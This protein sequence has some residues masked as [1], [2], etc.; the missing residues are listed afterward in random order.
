MAGGVIGLSV[1]CAVARC[2][3]AAQNDSAAR[4]LAKLRTDLTL[5]SVYRTLSSFGSSA[6]CS[7]CAVSV[8][9]AASSRRPIER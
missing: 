5:I 6:A 3:N 2:D 8:S 1:T 4:S 9:L 7:L